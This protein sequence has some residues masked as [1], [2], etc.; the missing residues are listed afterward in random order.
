[1]PPYATID[2]AWRMSAKLV[3]KKS[4]FA[5]RRSSEF[6]AEESEMDKDSMRFCVPIRIYPNHNA[7]IAR[8]KKCTHTHIAG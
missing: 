1:M 7:V 3:E 4:C 8:T 5:L 2:L 6:V